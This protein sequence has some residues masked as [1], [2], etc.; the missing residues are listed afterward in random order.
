MNRRLLPK[1]LPK[2]KLE[3]ADKTYHT[4]QHNDLLMK[5]M[6][7]RGGCIPLLLPRRRRLHFQARRKAKGEIGNGLRAKTEA[8]RLFRSA[9]TDCPNGVLPELKALGVTP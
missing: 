8:T 2:A 4:P 9:A 5:L 6:V 3:H 7:P 1:L